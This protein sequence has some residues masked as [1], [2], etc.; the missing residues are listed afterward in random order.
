[1]AIIVGHPNVEFGSLTEVLVV[2]YA[3]F[4]KAKEHGKVTFQS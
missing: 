3:L 2:S 4:F 1:M